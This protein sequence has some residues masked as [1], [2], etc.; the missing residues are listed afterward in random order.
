MRA[1]VDLARETTRATRR[2]AV[3]TDPPA[4]R[5]PPSSA[6]VSHAEENEGAPAP[7]ERLFDVE[8]W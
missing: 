3:R 1:V 2:S 5:G 6:A 7:P 8:E 4:L